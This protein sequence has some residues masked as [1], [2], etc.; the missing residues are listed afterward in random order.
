MFLRF[1]LAAYRRAALTSPLKI[2]TCAVMSVATAFD[3][4]RAMWWV[5]RGTFHIGMLNYM[6]GGRVYEEYRDAPWPAAM[7]RARESE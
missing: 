1:D 5:V 3:A 6:L 7:A 2:L 4:R